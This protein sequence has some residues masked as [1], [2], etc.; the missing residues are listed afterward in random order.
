M[1]EFIRSVFGERYLAERFPWETSE[2]IT[3]GEDYAKQVNKKAVDLL[4]K[5]GGPEVDEFMNECFGELND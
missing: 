1:R 2:V 4:V 3:I 5:L